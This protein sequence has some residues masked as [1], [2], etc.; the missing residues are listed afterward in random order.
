MIYVLFMH[1]I[2][3]FF[4]ALRARNQLKQVSFD[5]V[6]RDKPRSSLPI[7]SQSSESS[8][9]KTR[10]RRNTERIMRDY[11]LSMVDVKAFKCLL[12]KVDLF[13]PNVRDVVLPLLKDASVPREIVQEFSEGD[14]LSEKVVTDSE[15]ESLKE[16]LFLSR[17]ELDSYISFCKK[18]EREKRQT[19][20]DK[21][22]LTTKVQWLEKRLSLV[23]SE[24]KALKLERAELLNQIYKLR[25]PSNVPASER[26]R[27]SSK[28]KDM[29]ESQSEVEVSKQRLLYEAD[30][31]AQ[32]RGKMIKERQ[33]LDEEVRK[34]QI[35]CVSLLAQ[36]Q[37]SE[38]TVDE[39]QKENEEMKEKLENSTAR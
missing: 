18:M 19:M 36:L 2:L 23:E 34:V 10:P 4:V 11:R 27:S 1:L 28:V 39:L 5:D 26:G 29:D 33:R 16:K 9:V 13:D 12:E 25:C 38:K 6:Q 20:S 7:N 17:K 3:D 31:F 30:A 24:N 15:K 14:Q 22:D 32:E 21:E 8:S 37:H 35:R